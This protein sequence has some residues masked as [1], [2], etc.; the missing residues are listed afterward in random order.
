MLVNF[1]MFL[2]IRSESR[3]NYLILKQK[4]IIDMT[5]KFYAGLN[6]I[7]LAAVITPKSLT[8]N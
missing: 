5:H 4:P 6:A 2:E 7:T 1:N 3:G 8:R